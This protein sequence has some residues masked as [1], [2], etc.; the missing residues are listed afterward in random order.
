MDSN[1][2]KVD[3][4]RALDRFGRPNVALKMETPIDGVVQLAGVVESS[5]ADGPGFRLVLFSQGCPHNCPGCHNP[6]T[7][8][9][10]GGE[11]LSFQQIFDML[12][13]NPLIAGV[14]FSGGEPFC[15]AETFAALGQALKA[16]GYNVMTYT[17]Y[18]LAQLME[19][20]APERL[21]LLAQTD[22]LVDGPFEQQ[23]RASDC[24]YRGSTNQ[25]I[26]VNNT[27]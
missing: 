8:P 10:T 16:R 7:H 18:T 9:F 5:I 21:A 15:Q 19:E 23:K 1:W 2:Q 13:K 20:A 6:Q 4:I 26:Y 3:S 12:R 17:G 22:I 25:T 27:P 14:T 24:F 11:S